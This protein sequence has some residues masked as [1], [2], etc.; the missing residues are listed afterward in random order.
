MASAARS[1]FHPF[2]MLKRFRP[3]TKKPAPIPQP[4]LEQGGQLMIPLPDHLAAA[5]GWK[6]GERINLIRMGSDNKLLLEKAPVIKKVLPLN[7][8]PALRKFMTLTYLTVMFVILYAAGF[9]PWIMFI[10]AI[11]LLVAT[12][13]MKR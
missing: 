10:W 1:P 11:V 2:Y 9:S 5:L 13:V 7:L 8:T 6:A 3:Q 12:I 4:I